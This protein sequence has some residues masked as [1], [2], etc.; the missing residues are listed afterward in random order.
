MHALGCSLLPAACT[1]ELTYYLF[2]KEIVGELHCALYCICFTV[3]FKVARE[4]KPVCTHQ[5]YQQQ[6]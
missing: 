4:I 3:S 1:V 5:E 2:P 6:L